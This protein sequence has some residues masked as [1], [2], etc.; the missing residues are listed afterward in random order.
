MLAV[1]SKKE[2]L[3]REAR[4]T[5]KVDHG[6]GTATGKNGTAT[7]KT[8]KHT[9]YQRAASSQFQAGKRPGTRLA[10]ERIRLITFQI[11]LVNGQWKIT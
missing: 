3:A 7:G 1:G 6:K 10:S 4:A 9:R 2:S 11:S 5:R 8:A